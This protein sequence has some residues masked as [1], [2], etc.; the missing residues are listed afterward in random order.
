MPVIAAH[1]AAIVLQ[2]LIAEPLHQVVVNVIAA[3]PRVA[4]NAQRDNLL[5][6]I[7]TALRFQ[8]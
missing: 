4:I 1:R 3:Q 8:D 2:N 5:P 6:A 7:A